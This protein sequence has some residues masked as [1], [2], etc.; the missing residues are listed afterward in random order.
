MEDFLDKV[1]ANT[2]GD[3]RYLYAK[4]SI[5]YDKDVGKNSY[6]TL[7]RTA[8][9]LARHVTN[10]GTPVL[11]DGCGTGLSGLVRRAVVF[12]SLYNFDVSKETVAIANTKKLYQTLRVFDPE[13]APPVNMGEFGIITAIGVIGVG[14][15]PLCVFDAIIALLAPGSLFA[16]SFN[17]QTLSD[18]AYETKVSDYVDTGKAKLLMREYGDHLPGAGLKSNINIFQLS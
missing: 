11:D 14:A 5:T 16:F 7:A 12:R 13:D 2:S 1:Y 6:T 18:P 4:W 8:E 10:L 3:T 9:A 17:D 15:A